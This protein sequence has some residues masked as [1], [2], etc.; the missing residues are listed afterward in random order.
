MAVIGYSE[1]LT[2][3]YSIEMMAKWVARFLDGAFRLPSV[4]RM[5]QSAA[6]WGRYMRRRSNGGSSCLGAVNIWYNDQLC[7]QPQEEEGLP[8]RVVPA[9]RRGRLCRLRVRMEVFIGVRGCSACASCAECS[10]QYKSPTT[11]FFFF[12]QIRENLYY[13]FEFIGST[14]N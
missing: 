3:I 8:R 9:L 6:E 5:E 4:A 10:R 1:S 2:N 11:F 7:R 13:N 14:W 12:R